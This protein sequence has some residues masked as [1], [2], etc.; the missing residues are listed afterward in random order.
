MTPISSAIDDAARR[1]EL[2][3]KL[4]SPVLKPPTNYRKQVESPGS[5]SAVWMH[6]DGTLVLKT[7]LAFYLDGCDS[8]MTME[9]KSLEQESAKLVEREKKVYSHLG[10]HS[11]I[12]HCLEIS[13]IGLKFPYME[14]GNLRT[15]LRNDVPKSLH[16]R[17]QWAKTALAAFDYIHSQGV[18]QGDVSARNLLVADNLSI[19]LSDFSG[20]KIGD[21][22]S[23]VRPE[24]RYEKQGAEVIRISRAT[25]IF[26]IGSLIYEII[27]GKPPYDELEDDDVEKLFKRA[28]F[29]STANIY[30][31]SIIRGCWLGEHETVKQVL[32]AVGKNSSDLPSQSSQA[33][34]ME[35]TTTPSTA[36]LFSQ[37]QFVM[38]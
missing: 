27:T 20:S 1:R 24:T 34:Q 33:G 30:L 32:D 23:L 16:I 21:E 26:A 8:E 2:S 31:G 9:Y 19:V 10:S 11:S 18:F 25:D 3:L 6:T 28:E 38:K 35:N 22:E 29:P 7:P 36:I 14:N 13:D 37:R 4:R 12:L 15:F 5:C 17:L